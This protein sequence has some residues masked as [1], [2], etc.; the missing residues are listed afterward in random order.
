MTSYAKLKPALKPTGKKVTK[1]DLKRSVENL[2]GT[3]AAGREVGRLKLSI[4]DGRQRHSYAIDLARGKSSVSA[5]AEGRSDFEIACDKDVYV[6]VV[7]GKL[8]PADAFLKGRLEVHGS[9]GLAKRLYARA[10]R[11]GRGDLA[12]LGDD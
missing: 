9:L 1:T 8:S 2:A 10:T 6:E 12:A 7:T 5:N 3:L 4:L 11:G